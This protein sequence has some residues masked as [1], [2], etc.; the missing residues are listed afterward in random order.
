VAVLVLALLVWLGGADQAVAVGGAVVE[1][2]T[3]GSA[4][5]H[6]LGVQQHFEVVAD[7]AEGE[8]GSPR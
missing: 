7:R 6:Q 5:P 8:A 4:A 2:R 1:D 3:T